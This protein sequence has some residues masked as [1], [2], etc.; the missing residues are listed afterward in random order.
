M[1]VK[2]ISTIIIIVLLIF[3][4]CNQNQFVLSNNN[5]N[6]NIVLEED[7]DELEKWFREQGGII[8]K[9]KYDKTNRRMVATDNIKAGEILVQANFSF[10]F[11]LRKRN[12]NMSDYTMAEILYNS[13]DPFFKPYL[14][15]LP[16]TCQTAICGN[17][18]KNSTLVNTTKFFDRYLD[19]ERKILGYREHLYQPLG[20][21]LTRSWKAHG[22]APVFDRFNHDSIKGSEVDFLPEKG[23]KIILKAKVDYAKGEEVFNHYGE[24]S[25]IEWLYN[26]NMLSTDVSLD[27]CVDMV[28]QKHLMHV[29]KKRRSSCLANLTLADLNFLDV[30]EEMKEALNTIGLYEN[31]NEADL[32]TILGL[33]TFFTKVL[34]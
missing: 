30:V 10:L 21:V 26:W 13:T 32:S 5:N 17:R 27:K 24:H 28:F 11:P 34:G 31:L 6:N 1:P 22:M 12:G 29:D 18:V 15:S 8:N 3:I 14:D 16:K 19:N 9:C 25:T 23:E 4:L 2:K 7:S 20:V 33:S